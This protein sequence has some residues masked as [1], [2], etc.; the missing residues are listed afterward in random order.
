M[1]KT[2]ELDFVWDGSL[3]SLGYYS[4]ETGNKIAA[5][6]WDNL[7]IA[8]NVLFTCLVLMYFSGLVYCMDLLPV[9][10]NPRGGLTSSWKISN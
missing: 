3:T 5:F 2:L 7:I 4:F 6:N 9:E 1:R 10:P 8:N